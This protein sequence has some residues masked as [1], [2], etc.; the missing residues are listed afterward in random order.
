MNA[1]LIR[2]E[3][4]NQGAIGVLLFDKVI[5]CFCLEPD[6]DEIGKLYISSGNYQCVRFHG[7]K[8]PNTFEILVPGHSA[9]LF[10]SGN[11]EADTLGCLL[12]GSSVGKL[13][14]DRAVLNSGQTFQS[15]LDYTKDVNS[16]PLE[17]IDCY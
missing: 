16:F 17:I 12:L 10:H 13:K 14:G 8:W 11:I 5:F 6:I 1:K 9:I 3:M 4:S 7:S 15:F 2:V